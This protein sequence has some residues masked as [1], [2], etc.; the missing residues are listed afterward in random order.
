MPDIVSAPLPPREFHFFWSVVLTEPAAV[1]EVFQ[2][3]VFARL[4]EPSP[5]LAATVDLVLLTGGHGAL[6]LV[7]RARGTYEVQQG[8]SPSFGIR[9]DAVQLTP[10][11]LDVPGSWIGEKGRAARASIKGA[12]RDAHCEFRPMVDQEHDEAQGLLTRLLG[13]RDHAA[14]NPSRPAPRNAPPRRKAETPSP[15]SSSRTVTS[16]LP[17]P[18]AQA[19]GVIMETAAVYALRRGDVV[20]LAGEDLLDGIM[21]VGGELLRREPG[22]LEPAARFVRALNETKEGFVGSRISAVERRPVPDWLTATPEVVST[23]ALAT[24]YARKASDGAGGPTAETLVTALL[25]HAAAAGEASAVARILRAAGIDPV[26]LREAWSAGASATDPAGARKAASPQ[27]QAAASSAD[28]LRTWLPSFNADLSSGDDK[29]GLKSDIEAMASLIVSNTLQPPLS[30]GLFGD[31]GSGKSF[32]MQKLRDRIGR[33]S[34]RPD[35]TSRRLYWPNVVTVEFNAWHYVDANLWASLVSHLFGELRRWGTEDASIAAT[36]KVQKENALNHLRV[37]SEARNAAQKKLDE[38][39]RVLD[40]A[41]AKHDEA[42]SS[43]K[44]NQHALS[45]VLA[46]DLWSELTEQP[47][48]KEPLAEARE[49]LRLGHVAVAG[50][51]ESVEKIYQEIKQLG[52]AGGRLRAT[53]W[54]MLHGDGRK[55]ALAWLGAGTAIALL[56]S[57]RGAW[58]PDFGPIAGV[59]AQVAAVVVAAAEWV[60]RSA[61]RVNEMLVPLQATRQKIEEAYRKVSDERSRVVALLKGEVDA[62]TAR[63]NVATQALAE[64]EKAVSAAQALVAEATTAR[65]ISRFIEVRAAS[66]DY[67]KHLGIVSTIRDDFEQLSR[68]ITAHNGALLKGDSGAAPNVAPADGAPASATTDLGINRIVLFIDDLDRCPPPRV[69]EVLQAIHLLLAFPL[70]VVVVGVDSR[71]VEHSLSVQYPELLKRSG[72]GRNGARKGEP[73]VRA[74]R[75]S[76]YLE[77]I[78]QI[79]YRVRRLTDTGS[80]DLIHAL[81]AG[82]RVPLAVAKKAE[83]SPAIPTVPAA[84]PPDQK[85]AAQGEKGGQVATPS[86]SQAP[87]AAAATPGQGT[88]PKVVEKQEEETPAPAILESLRLSEGEIDAMSA[89]AVLLTRSPRATKRFVNIYRLLKAAV[90][91]G[92]EQETFLEGAYLAPMLLL[93]VSTKSPALAQ[94]L[95]DAL[96]KAAADQT[97]FCSAVTAFNETKQDPGLRHFLATVR[98]E[99]QVHRPLS[100][101]EI[102]YWRQRVA[103]FSFEDSDPAP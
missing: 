22:T 6:R 97:P 26:R 1:E 25:D 70:F 100:T 53:G 2:D 93:A 67:R 11:P 43:A 12:G 42:V 41:L 62:S 63:V 77:K 98:K 95:G 86:A 7:G 5:Q 71:W 68:L 85:Q 81:V 16:L 84:N 48:L 58:K 15:A 57:W 30:I 72:V 44:V 101:R 54:A 10:T 55:V 82:D 61:R 17:P 92:A 51:L 14:T 56:L 66:E 36:V 35:E 69:V 76:D 75:P 21:Q 73:P 89:L 13:P 91:P 47:G 59:V 40:Q 60:T 99:P 9:F 103:Q 87:P 45:T 20:A 31:W 94:A 28:R 37:A 29:L 18:V 3:G 90:P 24:D 52:E 39:K 102:E 79:P 78:F 50:S 27:V 32:F 23:L 8:A 83:T 33:I 4:E 65:M 46:R 80:R 88:T 38:A 49:Q 74:A 64:A 19:V 96:G 34:R